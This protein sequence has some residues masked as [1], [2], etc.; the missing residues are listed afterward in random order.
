LETAACGQDGAESEA[1]QEAILARPARD[2]RSILPGSRIDLDW[3][4]ASGVGE[5]VVFGGSHALILAPERLGPGTRIR[6]SQPEL[7]GPSDYAVTW[8]AESDHKGRFKM[9]LEAV[10]G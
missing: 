3:G 8:C 7:A 4:R 5:A 10:S 9:A 2:T 6:V 1:E